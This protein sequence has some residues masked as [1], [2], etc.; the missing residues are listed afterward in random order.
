MVSECRDGNIL[1][2]LK[3]EVDELRKR[4]W[5]IHGKKIKEMK[6]IGLTEDALDHDQPRW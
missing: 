2:A 5:K 6:K 4:E 3:F 1:K